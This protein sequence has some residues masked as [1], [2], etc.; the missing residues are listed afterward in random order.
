M[1]VGACMGVCHISE[2][3]VFGGVE[4]GAQF[5]CSSVRGGRC[6]KGKKRL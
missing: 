6:L 2:L 1:C 4:A 3:C 5:L